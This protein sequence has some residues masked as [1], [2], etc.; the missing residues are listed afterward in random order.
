MIAFIE[1]KE[2]IRRIQKEDNDNM[3][4]KA[5]IDIIA[6]TIGKTTGKA[7]NEGEVSWYSGMKN[8]YGIGTQE[9]FDFHLG[10]RVILSKIAE[11][12]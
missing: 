7:F 2:L 1:T 3:T 8:P 12:E 9:Y 11:D 5:I 10:E 6:N 4:M